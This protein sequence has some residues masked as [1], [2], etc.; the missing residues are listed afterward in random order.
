MKIGV[1]AL[2]D[3]GGKIQMMTK[4][5][6]IIM[7][8]VVNDGGCGECVSDDN[9]PAAQAQGN[10]FDEDKAAAD[11]ADSAAA[12]ADQIQQLT[13]E[14]SDL[15][16][17]L[18]QKIADAE[19]LRKRFEREK[20][21]A[22]KYANGSFARDLLGV[23]DNF[24]RVV[25]TIVLL[26]QEVKEN[27]S[28]AAL[29]DGITLCG[30]ELTSVLRRHGVCEIPVAVGDTFDPGLHQAMCEV[31]NSDYASGSVVQLLQ[32]GYMYND[33]LLRPAMVNVSRKS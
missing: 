22:T 32:S 8:E 17:L 3:K 14:V 21:D 28:L 2:S 19:N 23:A 5:D 29:V 6:D 16:R 25:D 13:A 24:R 18:V 10:A 30:R 7:D 12:P 15:R 20:N 27:P 31:K 11:N 33:R 1:H 26:E 9:I 4:D